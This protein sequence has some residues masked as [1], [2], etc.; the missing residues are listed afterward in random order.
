[1]KTAT[2]YKVKSDNK[3]CQMKLRP[4]TLYTMNTHFSYEHI[5]GIVFSYTQ[6]LPDAEI[7]M[8]YV[9]NEIKK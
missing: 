8:Y 4:D 5:L 7:N 3:H 2:K 1:M 9:L 6:R